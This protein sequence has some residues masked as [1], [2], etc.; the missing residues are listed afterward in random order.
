MLSFQGHLWNV[1]VCQTL[2]PLTPPLPPPYAC[3]SPSREWETQTSI[4]PSWSYAGEVWVREVHFKS[5]FTC[6]VPFLCS[7]WLL[8]SSGPTFGSSNW[9]A[10][11]RLSQD[12]EG[13]LS[14]VVHVLLAPPRDWN[15]LSSSHVSG[16]CILIG[17]V[18]MVSWTLP[19][20]WILL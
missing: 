7:T 17:K 14:F 16:N 19:A 2:L 18:V 20:S 4:R 5:F 15:V 11:T 1:N 3:Q 13:L 8:I 9:M 10:V 12:F 6:T